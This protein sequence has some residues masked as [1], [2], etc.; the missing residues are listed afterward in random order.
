ME[1][2]SWW[3]GTTDPVAIWTSLAAVALGFYMAWTIGAND[4]AN[5]MGTSV[6]SGSLKYRQAILVAAVMEFAGATLAGGHV[7]NTIRKG[8][9]DPQY[10]A[11]DPQ[12]LVLGMLSVLLASALWLHLATWLSLPVST[13]HS[14]VGALVGFGI[15]ACGVSQINW[16]ALVRIAASWLVSPLAGGLLSFFLFVF[17]RRV[18][19]NTRDP[20]AAT[21][22][23][24][25]ILAGIT[26]A[27]LVLA[28]IYEGLHNL[29]FDFSFWQALPLALAA[30]ALGW[31]VFFFVIRRRGRKGK[32]RGMD[33]V[34]SV[35]MILQIMTAAYVA[36]AHGANDVANAVGPVAAVIMMTTQGI[37]IAQTAV[38]PWILVL[39]GVGI[40]AGL[41]TWGYKVMRTVGKAITELTPT[42]GFCAEFSTATVVL[43]CSKLGL[44]MSTTHT[45]VGAVVGVGLA[46]GLDSVNLRVVRSILSSWL[47]TVPAAGGLS[48][49]VFYALNYVIG[50]L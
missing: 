31:G 4:V 25:P 20:I 39:G 29:D 46:R 18:I 36:F 24:G 33:Y 40:L 16:H 38:P 41:A 7:T 3:L 15:F 14:V 37:V 48:V 19:L 32:L 17:L 11:A 34:E 28:T 9:L 1:F 22:R 2:L 5:A 43:V 44:P 6:G 50:Q 23:I 27:N 45:L 42:R 26:V 49:G 30:G 21:L 12:L 10:F 47:L 13:T 35:F 8:I